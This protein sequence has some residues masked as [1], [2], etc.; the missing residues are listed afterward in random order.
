M[1]YISLKWAMLGV[2]VVPP[3]V[4]SCSS[5]G[6][7]G[8]DAKPSLDRAALLDPASCKQCH[9][10]HYDQWSGSMHAYA[11]D[12]PVFR[13]MNAR[14]QRE[15]N[16]QLGDF[17]VK[18]HAPMAVHENATKDGLNLDT[19]PQTLKGVTCFFCHSVDKIQGLH[20]AQLSLSDDMVMRGAYADP[21]KN[22][23]HRAGY[24]ALHDGDR[25]ESANLCGSC[26]D[27]ENGHGTKIERTFEE[28]QAS[29]FAHVPSGNTCNQCHMSQ[30]IGLEPIAQNSPGVFSRHT[31]EHTLPG[32]DLA[33]TPFP[34]KDVQRKK[35]QEFL[36]SSIQSA[37]CAAPIATQGGEKTLVRVILD[38]VRA[39]H[40]FPSGS[41]QDRRLWAEVVGYSGDK[42][43]FESGVVPDGAAATK[44]PDTDPSNYWLIRDCMFDGTDPGAKEVHMFWEA[45]SYEGNAI[46]AKVTSNPQDE[47]FYKSHIIR[48]YPYDSGKLLPGPVDRITLRIRMRAMDRDVLDS[49]VESHDLDPAVRD[50]IPTLDVGT[51]LTWTPATATGRFFQNGQDYNCITETNLNLKSQVTPAP[52]RTRCRP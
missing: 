15:T 4:A 50:A 43:I 41:V 44:N 48:N 14:G 35:V 51:T 12:D 23:A 45:K 24:S 34:Q 3:L 13:A 52:E 7:G 1:T 6:D 22:S 28:W 38:N 8:E 16:G 47:R 39:G 17:C 29:V 11:S 18:C 46:P 31:H 37:L 2:F 30:S 42:K 9:V 36:D 27:I 10:N 26:H 20:N 25:I 5:S 49:L 21:V 32:V 40:G 33:L 19:L